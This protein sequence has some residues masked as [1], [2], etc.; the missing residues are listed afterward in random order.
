M[1]DISYKTL[2]PL[3][4]LLGSELVQELLT[5]IFTVSECHLLKGAGLIQHLGIQTFEQKLK[6]ALVS[7]Y[8]GIVFSSIFNNIATKIIPPL[9]HLTI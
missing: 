3:C 4:R 5:D 9:R 7:Q 2:Y 1:K 8:C 6:P